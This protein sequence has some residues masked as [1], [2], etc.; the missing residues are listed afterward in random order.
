M[1]CNFVEKI[2]MP[3]LDGTGPFGLSKKTGRGLGLCNKSIEQ[4]SW[5]LGVG[6]GLKKKNGCGEGLAKR[7]KY[8]E[9]QSLTNKQQEWK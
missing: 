2:N 3:K 5:K 8:N 6:M 9:K 4:Q 1:L 7:L